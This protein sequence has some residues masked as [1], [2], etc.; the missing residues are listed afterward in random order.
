VLPEIDAVILDIKISG[1]VGSEPLK[2]GTLPYV[3]IA[4]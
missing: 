4:I 3:Q 1:M 2:I